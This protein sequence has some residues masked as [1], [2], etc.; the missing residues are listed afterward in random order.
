VGRGSGK[1]SARGEKKGGG[2]EKPLWGGRGVTEGER[3]EK[4]KKKDQKGLEK[5][6]E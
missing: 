2:K 1:R 3:L 6:R 4:K 5:D